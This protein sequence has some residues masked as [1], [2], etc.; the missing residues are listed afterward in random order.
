MSTQTDELERAL[1]HLIAK[2]GWLDGA[3]WMQITERV[4]R[5]YFDDMPAAVEPE[6][7]IEALRDALE[8]APVPTF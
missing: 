5:G 7:F 8:R 4:G 3:A 2:H 6:A 1:V